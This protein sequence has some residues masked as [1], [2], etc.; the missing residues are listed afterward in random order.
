MLVGAGQLVEQRGFAAVLVARQCK[1][2]R[3]ILRQRVLPCLDVEP[4]PLA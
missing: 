1:G 3:G 4:S 2:Q